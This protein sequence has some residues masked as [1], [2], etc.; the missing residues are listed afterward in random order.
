[1]FKEFVGRLTSRKFLLSLA[2][3][4]LFVLDG[5][6]EWHLD[7]GAVLGALS[8]FAGPEAVGDI[9]SRYKKGA[10]NDS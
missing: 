2:V 7:K 9:V 3:I 8:V 1:M 10:S 5:T 4:T 6:N